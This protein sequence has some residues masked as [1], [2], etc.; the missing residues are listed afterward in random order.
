MMISNVSPSAMSF[1]D[2][3]NTLKYADR[4]KKIKIKLK[5]NVHSVDFH[6]AQ[7]SKIVET[8]KAEI[9]DLK[10]KNVDLQTENEQLKRELEESKSGKHDMDTTFDEPVQ[11]CPKMIE[12]QETNSASSPLKRKAE[13]F[14]DIK[15]KLA[16]F[17][18]ENEN[19]KSQLNAKDELLKSKLEDNKPKATVSDGADN[20]QLMDLLEKYKEVLKAKL[21]SENKVKSL[22]FKLEFG[23]KILQRSKLVAIDDGTTNAKVT[24]LNIAE[25]YEKFN[26]LNLYRWK[27]TSDC[28]KGKRPKKRGKP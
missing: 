8:L 28:W 1:E 4:A 18:D 27:N 19:L 15:A 23:K 11:P 2:T 16:K 22:V 13:E 21:D 6:V 9:K 24:I 7:Y 5:K 10:D 20:N 14:E 3:Y 26:A 17:E 12:E 25:V